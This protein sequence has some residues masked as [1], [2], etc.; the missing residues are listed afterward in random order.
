MNVFEF[1][2]FEGFCILLLFYCGW[3]PGKIR[4]LKR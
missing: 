2:L 4:F 3:F 1:S